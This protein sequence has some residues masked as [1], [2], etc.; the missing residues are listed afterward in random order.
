MPFAIG[1]LASSRVLCLLMRR[2]EKKI[3][4]N[5]CRVFGVIHNIER[6][7][8][9][10]FDL[11]ISRVFYSFFSGGVHNLAFMVGGILSWNMNVCSVKRSRWLLLRR[12]WLRIKKPKISCLWSITRG[13]LTNSQKLFDNFSLLKCCLTI[14]EFESSDDNKFSSPSVVWWK[15][16]IEKRFLVFRWRWK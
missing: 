15:K 6:C 4:K 7:I 5:Y 9:I 1:W 10:A 14:R 12:K 11:N 3:R 2:N 8:K 16:R 13:N